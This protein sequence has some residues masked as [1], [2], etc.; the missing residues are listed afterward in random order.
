MRRGLRVGLASVAIAIGSAGT[1]EAA[2]TFGSDLQDAPGAGFCSGPIIAVP[3]SCTL[4]MAGLD[5]ADDAAGGAV[6][7]QKGVIVRWRVRR[8]TAASS[9]TVQAALRVLRGDTGAGRSAEVALPGAS[10]TYEFPTRLPVQAGDRLGIDLLDVP[11]L[12][13]V[14]ILRRPSSPLDIVDKWDPP[15]AEGASTAP[16][17]NDET[18]FELTMNAD[19]EPDADGD[20]FGDETQDLCPTNV[21]TQQACTAGAPD[22]SF[23]KKPRKKSRKTKQTAEFTSNV[24]GAVFQCSLDSVAFRNCT[25]PLKLKNLK[26]GK[27]ILLV[28]AVAFQI[29]DPTPAKAR[30]TIKKKKKGK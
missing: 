25:S 30:F 7:P 8:E 5:P 26:K 18:D 20:G 19:I 13:M 1:A 27:H 29:P 28:R 9:P 22:T 23:T 17:V 21:A 24:Q 4:A 10:G 11:F 3:A 12:A 2:I 14:N 6:A 16:S 15:L